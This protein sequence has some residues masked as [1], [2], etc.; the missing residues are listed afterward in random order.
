[1]QEG[2]TCCPP[3]RF[4]YVPLN[5]KGGLGSELG[6]KGTASEGLRLRNTALIQKRIDMHTKC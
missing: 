3:V 5:F 4:T 6:G 1:M 2:D